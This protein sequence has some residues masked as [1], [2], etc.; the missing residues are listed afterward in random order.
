MFAAHLGMLKGRSGRGYDSLG[1][2]VPAGP[3]ATKLIREVF[4]EDPDTA[5]AVARCASFLDPLYVLPHT[6]GSRS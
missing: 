6:N 2:Q 4:A 1:F 3:P 5:V